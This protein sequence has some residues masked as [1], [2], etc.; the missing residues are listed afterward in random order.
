MKHEYLAKAAAS[1]AVCGAGAAAMYFSQGQ[2]G[3]GWSVL[4]V[5]IIWCS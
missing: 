4:G 5:L 2:T 1:I 3:V